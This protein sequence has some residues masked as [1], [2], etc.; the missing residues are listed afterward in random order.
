VQKLQDNLSEE[1]ITFIARQS[2][3]FKRQSKLTPLMFL[4]LVL[5][6]HMQIDQPTLQQHSCILMDE[7]GQKISKQGLDKRF[8]DKAANFIKDVFEQYLK[9]QLS[10]DLVPSALSERFKAIR[11]LD[12]TE[13]KLPEQLAEAFPGFKGAGTSSC[14][15][16][17]FE[18]DILS[19]KVNHLF[20][21][22]ALTSDVVYAREQLDSL[23]EN[24]LVLRDLGYYTIDTYAGI[25]KRKAFY[26]SRLK[27][28]I[29]IYHQESSGFKE[30]T[31]KEIHKRLKDSALKYL[32]LQ[33]YIGKEVKHPVRLIVNLLD[34]KASAKRRKREKRTKRQLNDDDKA[35]HELNLFITNVPK[36]TSA[37]EIYELYK[38]RWQIEL[39]F[40]T[41]KSILKINSVRPMK[42]SRLKCYLISKL[43]WILISWDIS[44]TFTNRILRKESRLI[45]PYKS[46]ALIKMQ[47]KT[48]RKIL[49]SIKQKQLQEWLKKM[50]RLFVDY[51]LKEQRAN[52]SG[53]M[54]LLQLQVN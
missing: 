34:E 54:K 43:L 35:I 28:Y 53:I 46:F 26:V 29:S 9:N 38:I 8:S 12:S 31:Y 5:F 24:D 30:L 1:Q 23:S 37:Q 2:G 47:T 36:H 21:G 7:H 39:L 22:K 45:S 32:D 48:L 15:H 10:V 50:Y 11:I 6:D 51:G 19:G 33:V 42:A 27:P 25:E 52:K 49:F 44:K 18:Y 20:L 13:F 17:Q 41:W 3:F 4:K 40:K 16:I 14:A